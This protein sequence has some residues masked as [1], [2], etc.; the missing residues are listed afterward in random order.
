M[1]DGALNQ[2]REFLLNLLSS[3]FEII[4]SKGL[5]LMFYSLAKFQKKNKQEKQTLHQR[6]FKLMNALDSVSR[7]LDSTWPG[8]FSGVLETLYSHNVFFS[9][10]QYTL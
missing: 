9:I 4:K 3:D 1:F 8:S 6:I 10:W 5:M 2:G 7:G